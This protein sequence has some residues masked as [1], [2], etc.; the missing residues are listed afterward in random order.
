VLAADPNDAGGRRVMFVS[1]DDGE[2][3]AQV[4]TLFDEAGF[5]AIDLGDLAIGGVLQHVGGALSGADLIRL[6]SED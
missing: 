6:P 4:A 2:A 1:G 3:S 5:S